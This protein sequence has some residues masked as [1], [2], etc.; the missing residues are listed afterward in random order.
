M[1]KYIFPVIGLFLLITIRSVVAGLPSAAK[2]IQSG[3]YPSAIR[4]LTHWAMSSDDTNNHKAAC[5]LGDLYLEGKGTTKNYDEAWKWYSLASSLGNARA[6]SM[7]GLMCAQG[8]GRPQD[9]QK[10]EE[11]WKTA[12]EFGETS[13]QINLAVLYA[14]EK[15]IIEKQVEALTWAIIASRDGSDEKL[16]DEAFRI[17]EKLTLKLSKE[18]CLEAKEKA[19]NFIKKD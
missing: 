13:A 1:K 18:K 3:D 7:L 10:A 14:G 5:A 6:K 17:S 16:V 19:K 15:S 4:E 2:D 8:L 9:M 11:Y 12:A